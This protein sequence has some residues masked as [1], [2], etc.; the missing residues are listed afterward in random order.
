M[1]IRIAITG[2]DADSHQQQGIF[3]AAWNVLDSGDLSEMESQDLRSL[4]EWFNQHMPYPSETQRR[5]LSRRAIFW[6]KPGAQDYI[7]RAWE[8]MQ[9]LRLHGLL[10]CVLKTRTPGSVVY[11]DDCQIAA[12]PTRGTF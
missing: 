2:E 3:H 5:G 7:Q 8:L 6:F 11:A 10:V 9:L 1:F 4:L 12:I